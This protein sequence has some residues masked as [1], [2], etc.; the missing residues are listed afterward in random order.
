MS[1]AP[2]QDLDPS[3]ERTLSPP[4]QNRSLSPRPAS[5]RASHEGNRNA[6]N[7]IAGVL[8]PE[9][10]VSPPP[11]DAERGFGSGFGGRREEMDP[12]ETSLGIRMDYEACLAYLLLPPAA[13]VALLVFEHKSDYVRFHAWQSSLL[14]AFMFVVHIIFAWTSIVSWML[15]VGDLLLIT[16]LTFKTYKDGMFTKSGATIENWI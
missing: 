14:F 1:F 5:P 7:N 9:R 4:P 3:S 15:F 16:W 2:Y 13:G 10:V 12:F 11:R 8:S 6:S